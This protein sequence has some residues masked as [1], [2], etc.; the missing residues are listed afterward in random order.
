MFYKKNKHIRV[1]QGPRTILLQHFRSNKVALWSLRILYVLVFVAVF[2]DFI[3]NEKPIFCSIESGNYFP[4]FRQY[5]VDI[6]L[7]D[8]KAEL[9]Q[10]DW[11]NAE[12]NVVFFPPI[13]YSSTTTDIHDFIFCLE[14][15][16]L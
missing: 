6:G 11:A 2:G 4:V 13:P 1:P 7:L 9:A 16:P 3:A 12:Y 8:Q 10:M 14:K 5:G 15:G